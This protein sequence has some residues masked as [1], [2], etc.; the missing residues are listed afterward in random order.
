MHED[1]GP[2]RLGVIA[3][4]PSLS[5]YGGLLE[6]VALTK[7]AL[8]LFDRL[9]IA[10]MGRLANLDTGSVPIPVVNK[11]EVDDE[12]RAS[13]LSGELGSD[14]SLRALLTGPTSLPAL[15]GTQLSAAALLSAET[16]DPKLDAV[17]GNYRALIEADVLEPEPLTVRRPSGEPAPIPGELPML[18]HVLGVPGASP[19]QVERRVDELMHRFEDSLRSRTPP[20][21]QDQA[22]LMRLAGDLRRTFWASALELLPRE[23]GVVSR[24]PRHENPGLRRDLAGALG[25]NI[26]LE[27][28]PHI[29][30]L[31]VTDI[32]A[33]V[34]EL[35]GPIQRFRGA[36]RQA[37]MKLTTLDQASFV[38]YWDDQVRPDL[39][40]LDNDLKETRQI[41]QYLLQLDAADVTAVASSLG[42]FLVGSGGLASML[43]SST[44]L[45]LSGARL[46]ARRQRD[47]ESVTKTHDFYVL[48]RLSEL[49]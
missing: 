13:L 18:D 49:H 5:P 15:D 19:A 3:T 33:I 38:E 17:F 39:V 45:L 7:A 47:T 42:L 11:L 37:S 23:T 16:D 36:V 14:D 30:E 22:T 48:R 2:S 24:G 21:A 1:Y 44:P 27:G 41:G 35:R 6:G 29:S 32:L 40:A 4:D 34:D 8:L 20:S 25:V 28:L 12:L 9:T 43:A 31:P 46:L 10:N 26:V